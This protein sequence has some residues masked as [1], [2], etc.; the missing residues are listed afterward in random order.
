MWNA[1]QTLLPPLCSKYFWTEFFFPRQLD[2]HWKIFGKT[3]NQRHFHISVWIL[4]SIIW[5]RHNDG[6]GF[7]ISIWCI[8]GLFWRVSTFI[9]TV[10]VQVIVNSQNNIIPNIFT[11]WNRQCPINKFCQFIFQ[12]KLYA[13]M[14]WKLITLIMYIKLFNIKF[15]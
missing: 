10:L 6:R 14:Y 2:F 3:G 12:I 5:S 9:T 8:A 4:K 13:W 1:D 7:S 11:F 15:I